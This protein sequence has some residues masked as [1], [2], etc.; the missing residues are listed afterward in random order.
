MAAAAFPTNNGVSFA[1]DVS[2][3]NFAWALHAG[4]SY[5]VTK[6]FAVELSYRYLDMG[7]AETGSFVSYDFSQTLPGSTFDHLT[8]QDIRIGLRF[9]L[10][11]LDSYYAAPPQ[12]YAPPPQPVY[13]PPVYSQPP[14]YTQPPL[15]SKG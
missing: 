13:A 10:D 15:R 1:D 12:Y 8:S 9:N 2:K 7:N 5:K 3:W 4:L 14:I 11:A 6:N